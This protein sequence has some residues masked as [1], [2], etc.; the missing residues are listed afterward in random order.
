MRP[1]YTYLCFW[2]E[3]RCNKGTQGGDGEHGDGQI[4]RNVRHLANRGCQHLTK[5]YYFF[6]FSPRPGQ[7]TKRDPPAMSAC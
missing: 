2:Q 6:K 5:Y 1:A 7:D 4:R 3:G